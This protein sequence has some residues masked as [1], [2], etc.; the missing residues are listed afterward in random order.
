MDPRISL[1][2][3]AVADVA[4]SRRFYV[5][6]LGWPALIDQPGILM[7]RAG[8][9]LVLSLWEES[10]FV[11]EVGPLRRGPGVLG[12]TLAHNVGTDTEVD[13]ILGEVASLGAEVSAPVRR[14]WG[15]Y[16]GYFTDPDGVHW[17][18]AC[19]GPGELAFLVP[20]GC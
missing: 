3:I 6:G 7:I 9:R 12:C 5:D 16:S 2:T 18:V 10:E 11:A 8:E 17:E 15:G 14:D 13:A 4:R 20:G 19:T 1:I